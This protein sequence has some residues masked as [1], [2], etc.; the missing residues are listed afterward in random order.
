MDMAPKDASQLF[1]QDHVRR[2]RETDGEVG[3][4]WLGTQTLLLT[5]TGRQSG[6]ER[7]SPLIYGRA[8]DDY[9]IVASKG[10][11]DRPPSWYVNLRDN[12][13]V[14]VQVRGERFHAHARTATDD[15][16]PQL[17][18]EMIGHWPD[19]DEYQRKTDR[20]IPVVVLERE[21]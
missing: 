4:D 21:A 2:Y 14:D 20:D 6:K 17:W 9:L 1:G 3:H 12:P 16:K 7:T 10:G 19:Y 15:E 13:E 11:A 8:G 5:T 18:H